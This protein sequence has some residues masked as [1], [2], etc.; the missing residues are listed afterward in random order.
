M[1]ADYLLEGKFLIARG[2][3]Q[4]LSIVDYL[5][6][7]VAIQVKERLSAATKNIE[8]YAIQLGQHLQKQWNFY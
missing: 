1:A 2:N 8:P 5:K 6:H 3:V 7:P 4:Y